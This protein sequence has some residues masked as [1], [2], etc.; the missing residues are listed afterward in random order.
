M[1]LA[2]DLHHHRHH[3]IVL[4]GFR[5]GSTTSAAGWNG[6]KDVIIN[7]ERVTEYGGA[8]RLW[9]RE[10]LLCAFASGK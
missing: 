8:A 5:R 6:K 1:R 4:S 2:G 10:D 9:H 7:T 3:A